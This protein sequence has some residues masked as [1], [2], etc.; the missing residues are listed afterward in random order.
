VGLLVI[1]VGLALL[2]SDRGS[3]E[4][5]VQVVDPRPAAESA[6]PA[7]LGELGAIRVVVADAPP[8]V[9]PP[10]R[11]V[12]VPDTDGLFQTS[13]VALGTFSQGESLRGLAGASSGIAR[14][15][16]ALPGGDAAVVGTLQRMG[17]LIDESLVMQAPEGLEDVLSREGWVCHT[18]YLLLAR[19]WEERENVLARLASN[20]DLLPSP[21]AEAL[22]PAQRPALSR[23][24]QL[25]M[26]TALVCG[27]LLVLGL[28]L[29]GLS[30]GDLLHRFGRT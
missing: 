1:V 7:A 17:P 13:D 3:F 20:P 26:A 10:A 27:G 18:R 2:P 19:S 24:T 16:L 14:G 21:E 6:M 8:S 12:L 11:I 30:R 9:R 22:S 15:T 23:L 28:A 4:Y 5:L 29:R 25:A